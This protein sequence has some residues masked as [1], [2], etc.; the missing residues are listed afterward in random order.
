M[1]ADFSAETWRRALDGDRDAFE[2]SLAPFHDDLREAATRLLDLHRETG[3]LNEQSLNPEAL[4][5]ETFVRAW[6]NRTRFDS[7]RL[8][9]RAWLLGV[10]HRALARFMRREARYTQAKGLSLNAEVPT[11][12]ND[13]AVE[14][15]LY[16]FRQ[17]F[18]VVT[19]ADI[20]AGSEPIDVDFDP[21]GNEPLS[22][23]EREALTSAGLDTNVK[24]AVV[25]HDEFDLTVSEVAQILDAS[26]KDTAE[27]L[28]LARASVR[29]RI[30]SAPLPSDPDDAVDSYT[31]DPVA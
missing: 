1:P 23:R 4:V 28:N 30:G 24:E 11:T 5:G 29:E 6:E 13:D 22:D 15:A 10:Q 16:E 12:E 25:L 21:S 26:L 17:P 9:F 14:E 20:V 27:N 19:Y 8:S 7:D 18:E 3:E 31:G 2:E